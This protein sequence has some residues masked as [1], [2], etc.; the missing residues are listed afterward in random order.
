M[1]AEA[2][3][4]L[5]LDVSL[6]TSTALTIYSTTAQH[7]CIEVHQDGARATIDK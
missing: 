5:M 6:E 7:L 2:V 4:V 3:W 1:L